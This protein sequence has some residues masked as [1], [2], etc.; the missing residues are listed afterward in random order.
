MGAAHQAWRWPD[1]ED[2]VD[3]QRSRQASTEKD[4]QL[5]SPERDLEGCDCGINNWMMSL[6]IP[7]KQLFCQPY[8]RASLLYSKSGF[9]TSFI[10][11]PEFQIT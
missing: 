10:L 7:W 5:M 3:G 6:L 1:P 9:T 8:E 2:G 11:Q 4:T